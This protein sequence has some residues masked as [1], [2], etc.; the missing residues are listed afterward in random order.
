MPMLD[1]YEH[2]IS[3]HDESRQEEREG[4]QDEAGLATT[5]D[6][7]GPHGIETI[8]RPLRYDKLSGFPECSPDSRFLECSQEEC[9]GQ[10]GCLELLFSWSFDGILLSLFPTTSNDEHEAELLTWVHLYQCTVNKHHLRP[11]DVRVSKDHRRG[12]AR[13]MG[14]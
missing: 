11:L 2:K 13:W 5:R 9:V 3:R 8:L 1:Q 10:H 6:I 14:M 7:D 12:P 4:I